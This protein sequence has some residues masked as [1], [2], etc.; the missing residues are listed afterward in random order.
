MTFKQKFTRRPGRHAL[1]TLGSAPRILGTHD[2][3]VTSL[4]PEADHT[5]EAMRIVLGH[6]SS[7]WNSLRHAC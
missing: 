4:P 5:T 3:F 7:G 2:D 1:R 6:T